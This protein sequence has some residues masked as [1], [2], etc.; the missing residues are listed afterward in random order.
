[1]WIVLKTDDNGLLQK[2]VNYLRRLGVF[3]RLFE[4]A[5]YN[6]AVTVKDRLERLRGSRTHAYFNPPRAWETCASCKQVWDWDN[7]GRGPHA[8]DKYDLR[9]RGGNTAP[10]GKGWVMNQHGHR[11]RVAGECANPTALSYISCPM[12]CPC[13]TPTTIEGLTFLIQSDIKEHQARIGELRRFLEFCR[14]S[15]AGFKEAIAVGGHFV[16]PKQGGVEVQQLGAGD[17]A[18][19]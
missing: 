15:E 2:I 3:H 5:T 6:L 12:W 10:R 14:Q 11:I 7:L 9:K 17:T 19:S 13:Y 18:D 16:F 4:G 1:M 8:K